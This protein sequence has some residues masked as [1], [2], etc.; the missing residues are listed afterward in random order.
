ML[1]LALCSKVGDRHTYQINTWVGT[2]TC[3]RVLNNKTAN[4]KWVSKLVVEKRKSQGK[5][6]VSEIMSELRRKYSVGITKGKA[7]RARSM[8]E[9]IIE[10]DAK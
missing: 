8:A 7:W 9:E 10:G 1:F 3:A 6:K 2:H 5:V 4:A